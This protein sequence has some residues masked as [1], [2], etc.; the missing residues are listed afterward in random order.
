M[1]D[2]I[3][4]EARKRCG[5]TSCVAHDG[6]PWEQPEACPIAAAWVTVLADDKRDNWHDEQWNRLITTLEWLAPRRSA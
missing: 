4:V 2:D 5:C 6:C 1:S 3:T